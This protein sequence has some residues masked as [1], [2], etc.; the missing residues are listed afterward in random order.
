[1]E[2]GGKIIAGTMNLRDDEALYGRYWGAFEQHR[3]LHF[4]V[5]YYASIEACISRGLSRFEAGAGGDFKQLRGLDPEF[6]TSM[7]FIADDRF[8]AA[9]DTHLERERASVREFRERLRTDRSQFRSV[10]RPGG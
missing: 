4:N 7:H 6:T 10:R 5:C 3:F 2:R 1:A 8:R 9:L